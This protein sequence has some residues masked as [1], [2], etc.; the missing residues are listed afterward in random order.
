L[1]VEKD[2]EKMNPQTPVIGSC[3][4]KSVQVELAKNPDAMTVCHC[5]SCRRWSG[6]VPMSINAGEH[7]RFQGEEFVARYSSSDW[8]E[9]GFCKQCGSHLFFRLKKSDHYFLYVGLFGDQISPRF[10]M[11]EF[12]DQ[13]PAFYTFENATRTL[14]KDEAYKMLHQYLDR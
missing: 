6:G 3:L 7:M 9:R 12:I 5:D 14:T 2:F 11:Q 1:I 8:A 4:C 13:K 10:E